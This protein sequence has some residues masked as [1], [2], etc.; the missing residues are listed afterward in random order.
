MDQNTGQLSFWNETADDA[1]AWHQI[2]WGR[3]DRDVTRLRQR[4]FKAAQAGDMKKVRNLQKLMMR[5][6]A[7]TL[8][9]VRRVAQVSRGRK[10]A[11]VDG[12]TALGPKERGQLARQLL[13]DGA[14]RPRPVKRVQIPKAN[15]K[16]RPLGIPVIRDRVHQARV[17]N[18]L[19]PEWE[20]RFEARSYGFRPGRGCHDALAAIFQVVGKPASHRRW[21]LDADLSA[22]FDRIDHSHLMRSLAGF[23]AR[24]AVEGWL[25]AGVMDRGTFA[26]TVEGTPQ[27]GVISPLLLNIA[28]HGMEEA[29]GVSWRRHGNS[30][31]LKE[32]SPALVRYADDFVVICHT[33]KDAHEAYRRLKEWFTPRG[34]AF[35]EEKT[36]V[37]H[38]TD[39]F[40]F[41]GCTVRT[42]AKGYTLVTPSKDAVRKAK[43]R[44]RDVVRSNRGKPADRLV[45]ELNSFLRGWTA[46]YRPWSSKRA[47]KEV[48]RIVFGQLWQWASRQ[49]RR[50][51]RQ[52]IAARYWDKRIPG[53][54]NRWIF[55]EGSAYVKPAA[56]TRIVRHVPV[57]GTHSKDDPALTGYWTERAARRTKLGLENRFIQTLAVRQRGR[58]ARCGLDLVEGAE[59]EPD[60]IHDWVSWFD[61]VRRTLNVHHVVH[62]Q[63]GGGNELKNLI[64]LHSQ[65]HQQHHATEV[66]DARRSQ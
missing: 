64:L 24:D 33:E 56:M 21:V 23:P 20:A 44:I 55:G 60:D 25:K 39:G 4:I 27:G 57:L 3:V 53:S 36:S 10:T 51:G 22:A 52:W 37:R 54:D 61:S 38:L 62:R 48:D 65:C 40:D 50:K 31:V 47:F 16:T 1:E 5:S 66:L 46:Y 2:D 11:G 49:H 14:A 9:S 42:Y 26:P 34:L 41:L 28:L 59:F 19:E 32:G 15:G 58:C 13:R 8:L 45:P 6:A 12:E 35:N 18:A 43:G 29:A 17:K 63:H 7:N 30:R